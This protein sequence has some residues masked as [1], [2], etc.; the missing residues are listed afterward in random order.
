MAESD[1]REIASTISKKITIR[2]VDDSGTKDIQRTSTSL[3]YNILFNIIYGALL[4]LNWGEK[5]RSCADMEQAI[6]DTSEFTVDL[7]IPECNGFCTVYLPLKKCLEEW[8]NM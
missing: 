8:N 1:L 2:E 4:S 5:C 6:V 7:F 3:E